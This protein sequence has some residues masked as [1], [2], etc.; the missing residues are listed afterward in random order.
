MWQLGLRYDTLDLDD[1][2]IAGGSLDTLTA[3]VNWYWQ[4]NFKF[5]LDYV[6]VASDRRGV[7][8]DP[9]ILEARMQLHW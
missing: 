2:A 9:S 5:A 4:K 6:K 7:S 8:D 1:G 3:G